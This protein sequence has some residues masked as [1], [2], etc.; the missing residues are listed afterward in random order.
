MTSARGSGSTIGSSNGRFQPR[1]AFTPRPDLPCRL[2]ARRFSIPKLRGERA[3]ASARASA[4][5]VP[6]K[7]VVRPAAEP[8]LAV[9]VQVAAAR[10]VLRL[11]ATWELLQ[12]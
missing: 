5:A 2:H 3:G 4:A 6:M 12:L 7:T 8:W 10:K 1:S 11:V 9:V